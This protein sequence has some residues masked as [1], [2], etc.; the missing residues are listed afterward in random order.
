MDTAD[1]PGIGTV[2]AHAGSHPRDHWGFVNPPVYRGSTVVF[3]DVDT[4]S[5]NAQRYQYGRI[6]NPSSEALCEAIAGLEQAQ[7]TVLTPSGLSACTFAILSVLG[8]GDH[9]LV[10]DNVYAPVRDFC[11]GA[12]RRFGIE[13]S[14]YDPLIGAGIESLFRPNT[15]AVFT[16]SPGSH[17]FELPDLPAIAQVAR[18]RD[19]LVLMDNTWATPLYLKPLVLGIDISILAATKYVA[20]H[21]DALVGTVSANS[22]AWARVAAFHKQLGMHVGPDDITLALRGLRT[23]ELRLQRHQESALGIARWLERQ[24]QVA[25]VLHPALESHPQ[26]AL[27]KRD[28]TGSSGVFSFVTTQAPFDA[29][30]AMLDGMDL[31]ALGRSWGG[32]ESLAMTLD[33]RV[34]RSATSWNEP[35]H[36]IRLQV[37]LENADDLIADLSRGLERFHARA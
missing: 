27:W 7:G 15:R 13:T 8:A 12:A 1:E 31:F 20:G 23:M 4:M 5:A 29:V 33:P 18:R 2:L 9:F 28:F 26:H 25:K 14:Y 37:G 17:T 19:A 32:F 11:D 34:I 21:S 10:P 3:P 30:K 6:K 36:L 24:P 16:E 22:R 35:G